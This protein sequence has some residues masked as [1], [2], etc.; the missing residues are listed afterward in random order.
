MDISIVNRKKKSLKWTKLNYVIIPS[1]GVCPPWLEQTA[2]VLQTWAVMGLT[3]RSLGFMEKKFKATFI[4][5]HAA[6]ATLCHQVSRALV[7]S[8]SEPFPNLSAVGGFREHTAVY[9]LIFTV[10]FS[11]YLK[12]WLCKFTVWLEVVMTSVPRPQEI[13]VKYQDNDLGNVIW[14]LNFYGQLDGSGSGALAAKI[15]DWN[16]ILD[17]H[18]GEAETCLPPLWL[19]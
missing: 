6:A 9:F 14:S 13:L 7:G 1:V 2:Q 8:Y 16:S 12:I 11:S 5:R 19:P 4:P 17:T 18:M 3:S 10:L 15:D